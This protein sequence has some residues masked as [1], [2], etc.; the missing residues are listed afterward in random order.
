VSSC[1]N[2][3]LQIQGKTGYNRFTT[4]PTFPKLYNGRHLIIALYCSFYIFKRKVNR[5][6]TFPGKK[7]AHNPNYM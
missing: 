7:N 4:S 1:K 2:S 3:L 6:K 5:K